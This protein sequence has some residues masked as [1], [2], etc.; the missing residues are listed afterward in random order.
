MKWVSIL[1]LGIPQDQETLSKLTYAINLA[2][3]EILQFRMNILQSTDGQ[4]YISKPQPF[5]K[6]EMSNKTSNIE[7]AQ[8]I[9]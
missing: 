2:S 6:F 1:T 5:S 7:A 8:P 3:E 9:S 4:L